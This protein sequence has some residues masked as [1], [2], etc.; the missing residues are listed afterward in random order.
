[1]SSISIFGGTFDPVHYGHLRTAFELLKGLQLDEV[2]FM[3]AGTPPHR[4]SPVASGELRLRMVQAAVE[5][6]PGFTVDDRELRRDGPS[7]S[8]DTLSDLRAEYPDR[9]L[10]LI[11]GM[12]AFIGLP[13]WHQWREILQLAHVV[14]AHRPGWRTPATGPLGELLV[15]RGTGTVA[16]LHDAPAGHIYIHAVTQL[17]IASTSVRTL[18]AR[19]RD[20]RFLMPDAVRD[21]IFESGCYRDVEVGVAEQSGEDADLA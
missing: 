21:I 4:G 9:S 1:L 2:R 14:V 8:V 3:P 13:K 6:Q 15:D 16:D 10:L 7:Y 11:V 18:I 5:G 12:D 19:G 20:P 17:E